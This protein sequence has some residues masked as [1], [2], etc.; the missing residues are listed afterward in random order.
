MDRPFLIDKP[1]GA[2]P[3][4]AL[5][6]LRRVRGIGES[7]KLAYAGRLDPLA[8]GLL[9]VVHGEQL[10]R[11]EEYWYL[12]KEYEA[13][14]VVGV[15]TDSFDLMGLPSVHDAPHPAPERIT[16]V[17][18]GLV[19]KID[20]SVPIFS[21]HRYQGL[22]LF[23]LAKSQI[24]TPIIVPVR[25]MS[26]SQIDARGIESVSA[27]ALAALACERISLVQGDFRQEDICRAWQVLFP[28]D[29]ELISVRL[30]IHCGSGTYIRSV[31]HE[32]GRR[33]G[34]GGVLASLRRTRIGQWRIT[35]PEVIGL[36]WP[37]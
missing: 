19:G 7:E 25:R 31:A 1:I 15:S 34:T 32:I 12:A 33:L 9:A 4:Q 18:R 36:S 16:S 2:T 27:H 23:A 17:I 30:S 6:L 24:E 26:I 13:D 28:A 21:S 20:L 8:S 29:S 14:V 11:Q 3:L 35:D 10:A 22:P 5:T 37:L